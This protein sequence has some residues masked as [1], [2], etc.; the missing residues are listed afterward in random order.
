M[1]SGHKICEQL[2]KLMFNCPIESNL[3]IRGKE[4]WVEIKSESEVVYT[5][6][7]KDYSI[8]KLEKSLLRSIRIMSKSEHNQNNLKLRKILYKK[9][10]P[11]FRELNI[12]GL[13]G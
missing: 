3:Y 1:M 8:E 9:L 7:T 4:S 6:K 10:R 5:E 12:N 2:D 13:L 11:H